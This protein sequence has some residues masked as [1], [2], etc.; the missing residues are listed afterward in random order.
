MVTLMTN[1]DNQNHNYI[2]WIYLRCIRQHCLAYMKACQ[3]LSTHR[4]S[5]QR[6]SLLVMNNTTQPRWTRDPVDLFSRDDT[7]LSSVITSI[8]GKN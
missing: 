4:F 7:I 2:K 6:K 8:K 3:L 1:I 5:A